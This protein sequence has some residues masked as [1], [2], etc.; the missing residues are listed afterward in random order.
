MKA[1]TKY[2]MICVEKQ[3]KYKVKQINSRGGESIAT[4]TVDQH[5]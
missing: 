3:G 5:Y 2:N 1:K 4:T